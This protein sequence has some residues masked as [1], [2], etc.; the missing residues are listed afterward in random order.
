MLLLAMGV[1]LLGCLGLLERCT[2]LILQLVEMLD[3]MLLG[4]WRM[5]ELLEPCLLS[6]MRS[7][8]MML[9]AQV[10]LLPPVILQTPASCCGHIDAALLVVVVVVMVMGKWRLLRYLP[11]FLI[12]QMC[13]RVTRQCSPTLG[14]SLSGLIRRMIQIGRIRLSSCPRVKADF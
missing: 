6:L 4:M 13:M 2:V 11:Y 12:G 14:L 7:G 8:R 1:L 3:L 9:K 10:C 5:P